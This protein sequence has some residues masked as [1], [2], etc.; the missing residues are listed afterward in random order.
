[1][2]QKDMPLSGLAVYAPCSINAVC[3]EKQTS[4]T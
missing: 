4:A 1:M 2:T 3:D